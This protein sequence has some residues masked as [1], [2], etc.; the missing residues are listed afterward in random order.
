MFTEIASR[1]AHLDADGVELLPSIYHDE[2]RARPRATMQIVAT[3]AL[4]A[5]RGRIAWSLEPM[6]GARGAAVERTAAAL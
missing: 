1:N 6:E 3:A 5:Y 4:L 2:R